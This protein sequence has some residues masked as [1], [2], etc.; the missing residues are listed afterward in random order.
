MSDDPRED[1]RHLSQTGEIK[2]SEKVVEEASDTQAGIFL[3]LHDQNIWFGDMFKGLTRKIDDTRQSVEKVVSRV[4]VIEK[5]ENDRENLARDSE[6]FKRGLIFIP[7]YLK[8]VCLHPVTWTVFGVV[9]A[10]TA[11]H[12]KFIP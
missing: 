4:E 10:W 2:L 11:H 3:M 5:R 6:N 7:A 9:A 8:K 1:L 12:F